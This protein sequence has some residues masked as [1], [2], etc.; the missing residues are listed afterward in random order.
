MEYWGCAENVFNSNAE[1]ENPE[2]AG[3]FHE[4]RYELIPQSD[5]E[6]IEETIQSQ[7]KEYKKECLKTLQSARNLSITQD[8]REAGCTYCLLAGVSS[9]FCTTS[10]GDAMGIGC[11]S[12]IY[13]SIFLLR[14][15]MRSLFNR[16]YPP[17]NP[18][19]V[20][21]ES[22]AINQCF[23][24]K[25]L[26]PII[27][28]K[29]IL[30]RTNQFSQRTSTDF[31]EFALGLTLFKPKPAIQPSES[32]ED[33]TNHLFEK[34][35]TFF[36]E[37]EE[38]S[39][40]NLWKLKQNISK[41]ICSLLTP[42]IAETP[43]YIYLHG[44]GGIGKTHFVNK[45]TE[46]IEE[47]IPQSINMENLV[48]STQEELEGS[49]TRPGAMLAIL[50]NQLLKNKHGSI[51]FM[52]EAT[53]LNQMT[54]ASK[55]VFNGDQSKISTS[56]FGSGIDGSGINLQIPPMLI[57]V[58]SNEEIKDSALKTRFDSIDFP[59]PKKERLIE[60]AKEIASKSQLIEEKH[61]DLED[62]NFTEWLEQSK[63]DNFRDIASQ[64]VP[65][66]LSK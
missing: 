51:I 8:A 46:W 50:R 6:S 56:Y 7:E 21:E 47:L 28:E 24:P 37:Y 23:I 4:P 39:Q 43:R 16:C 40:E 14:P 32:I 63:A 3:E 64:I 60:Y 65:A 13:Q 48:I 11:M 54:S 17:A 41:F 22:F 45:L 52:D 34:I 58:A 10:F 27:R 26:W 18:L 20:L 62:F 1:L 12:T 33:V 31:L 36:T 59:K 55:R 49:P 42:D 66:I 19:D 57:F 44:S 5:E 25:K 15:M 29:F 35:D 9:I 30:A 53:W 61:I 2:D 38:F